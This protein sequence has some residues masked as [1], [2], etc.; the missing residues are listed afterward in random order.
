MQNFLVKFRDKRLTQGLLENIHR[1]APAEGTYRLMEV[2]G[3]HTVAIYRFGLRQLLPANIELLSGPGCPVC[4]TD[5]AYIDK[6]IA[7]ARRNDVLLV[8]FG[9]LMKVPSSTSSL[10]KEKA[11][12]RRIKIVYSPLE[13][14]AVAK[15]NPSKK[16]VFLAVGFETTIPAVLA[17]MLQADADGLENLFLLTAHKLVTPAMKA[18]LQD[19]SARIDGFI[20]PGH[21]STI[22]GSKAYEFLAHDYHIPC[23]VAGFEPTDVLQSVLMLLAQLR[24]SRCQVENQYH[25]AVRGQ[26]NTKALALID[27]HCQAIDDHWR[28]IGLIRASG[29]RLRDEFSRWDITSVLEIN[30]E[31]LR[32]KPGCICGQIL[33]GLARP[34]D[35]KLFAKICT[36]EDPVGACMVSG[37]GSCAAA[38]KH[39]ALEE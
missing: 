16:V 12:G 13:A 27:K 34:A 24:D 35:C 3:T 37:E 32:E 30:P 15:D 8:T 11:Q 29:L 28:G 38:Y 36:P 9:D 26:G 21:V 19:G 14:L 17:S 6:A 1:V 23:V 22:I 2:C 39:Q 10:L 5:L 7:L 33:Q 20:C 31:P 25:R 18:L 4:V